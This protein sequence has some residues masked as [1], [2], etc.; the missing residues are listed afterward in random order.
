VGGVL[1]AFTSREFVCYYAKV[2]DTYLPKA[3]DLLVDIFLNSRFDEEET[4]KERK[5]V[6][7]EIHMQED[8]PD[9]YIHDLF[10]QNLWRGHPLGMPIIGNE[11]S[12][13]RLDRDFVIGYM[14]ENYRAEDIMVAVRRAMKYKVFDAGTVESFLEN[15]SEPRYS[16]KLSF[17]P[18][19]NNDYEQ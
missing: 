16:V 8:T 4:E 12:V 10:S 7:Q 17:K 5:V 13:E 18:R 9:D 15:N 2:L 3:V 11:K 19:K 1:N 14:K 6:L